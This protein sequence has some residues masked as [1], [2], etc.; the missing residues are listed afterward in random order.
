MSCVTASETLTKQPSEKRQ[1][2]FD[3]SN[4]MATGETISSID[5]TVSE[6]M[7]G[8]TSDLVITLP[9][10][11]GQTTTLWI[12]GGTNNTRY[13]VEMEVTTSAGQIIRADGILSVKGK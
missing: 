5:E 1:F 10:I 8:A 3:F 12:A 2:S 11:S 9:A 7:N 13:R 4:V 6:K